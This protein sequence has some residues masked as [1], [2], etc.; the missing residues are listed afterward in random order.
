MAVLLISDKCWLPTF[1]DKGEPRLRAIPLQAGIF[2]PERRCRSG[3]ATPSAPRP[4]YL[5]VSLQAIGER[6]SSPQRR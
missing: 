2:T 4:D 3:F 1:G 5:P 6:L